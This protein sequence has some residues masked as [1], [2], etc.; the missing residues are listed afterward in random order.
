MTMEMA[1][2]SLPVVTL[3]WEDGRYNRLFGYTMDMDTAVCRDSLTVLGEKRDLTFFMNTYGQAVRKLEYELRSTD[4]SRL[5]EDGELTYEFQ[6][7]GSITGSIAFKDLLEKDKEYEWILVATLGDGRA[8]KYYTRVLWG[9][10]FHLTEQ[11]QFIKDF[12][13]RTF[14]KEVS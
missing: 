11:L 9:D 12:H 4:K 1:S 2:A 3:G 8:V 7:D 6:S 5:I 14:D 10:N 13:D